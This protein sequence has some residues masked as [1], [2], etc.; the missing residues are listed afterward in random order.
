MR[1][2][3]SVF[4]SLPYFAL[5][6]YTIVLGKQLKGVLIS[7]FEQTAAENF[8]KTFEERIRMFKLRTFEIQ[9]RMRRTA[10]IEL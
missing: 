7:D 2:E 3:V 1:K 8:K 6:Y 4:F 10:S 9:I 5:N